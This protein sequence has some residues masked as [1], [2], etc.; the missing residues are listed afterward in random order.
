MPEAPRPRLSKSA[1]A[2]LK[3]QGDRFQTNNLSKL[4]ELVLTEY[5]QVLE[6]H[7]IPA[8]L[9]NQMPQQAQERVKNGNEIEVQDIDINW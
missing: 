7:I 1:I 5:Q 3:S 4:C 9:L 8:S 6:G 2:F